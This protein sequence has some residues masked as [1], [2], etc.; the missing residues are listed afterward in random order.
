MLALVIPENS[1]CM[2][3][4]FEQRRHRQPVFLD[5]IF[6][7]CSTG[8]ELADLFWAGWPPV[9]S[10]KHFKTCRSHQIGESE[11]RTWLT[12]SSIP[13]SNSLASSHV[14]KSSSSF[15]LLGIF[16]CF[17]SCVILPGQSVVAGSSTWRLFVPEVWQTRRLL[18]TES[19]TAILNIAIGQSFSGSTKANLGGGN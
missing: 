8:A 14:Q 2:S 3:I 19:P 7:S 15:H 17:R 6:L 5:G 16:P 10:C 1:L 4:E 12:I 18:A 11:W 13:L 9:H